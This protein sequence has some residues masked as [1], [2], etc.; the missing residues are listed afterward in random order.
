MSVQDQF[1]NSR[2]GIIYTAIC[3][4][5]SH[6]SSLSTSV[7]QRWLSVSEDILAALRL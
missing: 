4:A 6:S 1:D 5:S 2:V 7:A 3:N